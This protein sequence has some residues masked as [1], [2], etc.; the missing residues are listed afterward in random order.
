MM[1]KR[2]L[3]GGSGSTGSS[4]LKNILSRHSMI[5]AGSETSLFC[6]KPLFDHFTK[7]KWRIP[8]RFPFGLRNEG[9]HQYNG[10]DLFYPEYRHSRKSI[11]QLINRSQT[12]HEFCDGF[13]TLPM[14]ALQKDIWIEKTPGNAWNF[15]VF[16]ETF[17]DAGVIHMIRDPLATLLSLVRRGFNP[18]YATGVCLL[19]HLAALKVENHPAY[20]RIKYEDLIKEPVHCI[21][22][23]TQNMGIT[24]EE[25]MLVAT[26]PLQIKDTR[27]PS[28]HHDEMEDIAHKSTEDQLRKDNESIQELLA[29]MRHLQPGPVYAQKHQLNSTTT[30]GLSV[31]LGYN[32]LAS[33]IQKDCRGRIKNMILTERIKRASRAYANSLIHFPLEWHD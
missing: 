11:D 8:Y 24:F 20:I 5:F 1:K 32:V 9:Y 16:L 7:N 33:S 22:G 30:A 18:V 19:N 29:C 4:L 28:W 15:D 31:H 17:P 10:L 13:F 26:N 21:N 27:I 25:Q 2:W 6:K 14:E 3:I 12:F 23:L